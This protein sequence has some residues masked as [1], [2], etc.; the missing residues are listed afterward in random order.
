M[1]PGEKVQQFTS[2]TPEQTMPNSWLW[3]KNLEPPHC[4]EQILGV[5]EQAV[6]PWW[7]VAV[8]PERMQ[9]NVRRGEILGASEISD[10]P[11]RQGGGGLDEIHSGTAWPRSNPRPIGP[12]GAIQNLGGRGAIARTG[13][14]ARTP[15]WRGR[16][17]EGR[18]RTGP[19][20]SSARARRVRG[21]GR[22]CGQEISVLR[23]RCVLGP[24]GA[25]LP[26]GRTCPWLCTRHAPG[27]GKF[28]IGPAPRAVVVTEDLGAFLGVFLPQVLEVQLVDTCLVGLELLVRHLVGLVDAAEL[29]VVCPI[30]LK[31]R[32]AHARAARPRTRCAGLQRVE[33]ILELIG[34]AN[35]SGQPVVIAVVH[36]S[37]GNRSDERGILLVVR[38]ERIRTKPL[39][40]GGRR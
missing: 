34:A 33:V 2:E 31:M 38:L 18:I 22:R 25:S 23:S 7:F 27:R 5:N 16:R 24:C 29:T 9:A 6:Q 40:P 36:R 3:V 17:P 10:S 21:R 11:D 12:R 35:T 30:G 28:S 8:E 1:L 13:R 37:W 32:Y 19:G 14:G 15:Q 26:P 4:R 20:R 39:A